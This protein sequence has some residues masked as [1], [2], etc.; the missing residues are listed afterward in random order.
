ME[1]DNGIWDTDG[2]RFSGSDEAAEILARVGK[3]ALSPI[4]ASAI[5]RRDATEG[6]NGLGIDVRMWADVGVPN[7]ALA[8][9]PRTE[10]IPPTN[11]DNYWDWELP[12]PQQH[13][14][15]DY[16]F[17][18]HTAGDNML[19]LDS[20]Q[21]DRASAVVAVHAYAMASLSEKLPRGPPQPPRPFSG[22]TGVGALASTGADTTAVVAG[23]FVGLL[24]GLLVGCMS[25]K[26]VS[27]IGTRPSAGKH[28]Y[29][30]VGSEE[31]TPIS[32]RR[33]K[34]GDQSATDEDSE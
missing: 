28:Q 32:R 4:N 31:A 11:V 26:H 8:Q 20:D 17:F 10:Y 23:S 34:Q 29:A 6:S 33:Q 24:I 19:V 30:T 25:S 16:F 15:G 12:P 1:L 9:F 14:Q 22:T 7:W 3:N 21:M 13:F 27:L 5:L 18:H 2:I